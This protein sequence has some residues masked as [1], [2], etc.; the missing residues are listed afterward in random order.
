MR[1]SKRIGV[2]CNIFHRG[3]TVQFL[4]VVPHLDLV[5]VP[6][7]SEIIGELATIDDDFAFLD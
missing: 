5:V 2:N 7:A 6:V 4:I 1:H 3:H